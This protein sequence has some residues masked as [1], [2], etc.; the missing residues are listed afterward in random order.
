L[1]GRLERELQRTNAERF[2]RGA[3]N[4]DL[5]ADDAVAIDLDLGDA[6]I[7][8]Q[9]VGE[10]RLTDEQTLI[11]PKD[12]GEGDVEKS[13][14]AVRRLRHHIVAEAV[15]IAGAGTAGI[16]KGRTG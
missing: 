5:D 2:G 3:A 13:Q 6:A 12:A 10:R 15:I 14:D 1:L 9:H 16:D 8:R 11:E 4:A 7:D